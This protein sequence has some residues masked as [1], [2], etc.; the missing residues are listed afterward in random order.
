MTIFPWRLLWRCN[1]LGSGWKR[2]YLLTSNNS[3]FLCS[4]CQNGTFWRLVKLFLPDIQSKLLLEQTEENVDNARHRL[5]YSAIWYVARL[6]NYSG[7]QGWPPGKRFRGLSR[8]EAEPRGALL[9][10]RPRST[11]HGNDQH[12]SLY[13]QMVDSPIAVAAQTSDSEVLQ[14]QLQQHDSEGG[15]QDMA[16]CAKDVQKRSA[17][18]GHVFP[19]HFAP[20]VWVIIDF[21]SKTNVILFHR[22]TLTS[23]IV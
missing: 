23:C 5:L 3:R 17:N 15:V 12:C 18:R 21:L 22:H 2:Y 7:Q 6:R 19:W 1:S 16:S 20:Q 10:Q 8:A 4:R 14:W 9:S 13:W 11:Q